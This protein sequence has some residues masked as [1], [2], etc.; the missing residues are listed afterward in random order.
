MEKIERSDSEKKVRKMMIDAGVNQR[1]VA[2]HLGVTPQAVNNRLKRGKV[3]PIIEAI[4][5]LE[6]KLS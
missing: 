1:M 4:E 5:E 2:K 6:E 3:T